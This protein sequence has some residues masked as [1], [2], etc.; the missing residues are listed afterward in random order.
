[1]A[2]KVF[3]YTVLAVIPVN[4]V[5]VAVVFTGGN[6]P[7]ARPLPNPNGYDDF[8]KA[9]QMVKGNPDDYAKMSK[10]EL[11][12]LVATNTESLKLI[13]LGLNRECV[14]PVEYAT[15]YHEKVIT[16]LSSFKAMA[17]LL[18]GEGLLA[19]LEGRTNDA[20]NI[21]LEGIKFGQESTRGGLLMSKLV[22]VA[23]E[24]IAMYPL[25]RLTSGLGAEQCRQV[26]KALESI[27]ANEE[28]LLE[29]LEREK[30]WT[31]KTFGLETQLMGTLFNGPIHDTAVSRMHTTQQTRRELM[32]AFA[33]RA[34]E[35]E[36]GK[37]PANVTDLVPDYL[38]AVPK[39]P[40]T[41]KDMGLGH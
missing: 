24:S 22:D 17:L 12:A 30:L 41:G 6:G 4:L 5:I 34:Y 18:R 40:V 13:Q 20:A 2:G 27:D 7:A 15:N 33:A 28:P 23:C 1:M 38:K 29:T 31:R 39:D 19:E 37:P 14:M 9:G 35:L 3:K 16:E 8:V 36:N 21:Y 26:A 11:A 32:I 10:Q 25:T